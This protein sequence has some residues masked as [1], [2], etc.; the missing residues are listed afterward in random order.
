MSRR[1]L[2]VLR[3]DANTSLGTGHVIRCLTLADKLAARR[4]DIAVA[5]RELPPGLEKSIR[6]RG[7]QFIGMPGEHAL[8]DEPAVIRRALETRKAD[9]TVVD[10]YEIASEWHMAARSWSSHIM[11]ID[12]LAV[13]KFDADLLLNQNLGESAEAYS[14]LLPDGRRLLIGP[15]YALLRPQ[16]ADAR[17]LAPR[18]RTAVSRL[19]VFLSG[20]DEHD[21]TRVAAEVGTDLELETDVVVGAA[22]PHWGRLRAWAQTQTCVTLHRNVDDMA[23]LM[24]RADLSIGAP[25]SATWERCCVG[26]PAILLTLAENQRRA[27]IATA[28][29]G[30]AVDLGWYSDVDARSL[31]DAVRS[32]ARSP[33]DLAAMSRSAAAVTDGFGTTRVEREIQRLIEGGPTRG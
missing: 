31:A 8:L 12:D 33:R 20:S 11:V 30:A 26:L 6:A 2:A 3:A 5:S 15:M 4:W 16:F 25:S 1:R 13:D 23:A 9:L 14:A 19:L 32:V 10:H 29:A 28:A 7:Y 27:A 17:H 24:A 21:V 22:Y 18:I